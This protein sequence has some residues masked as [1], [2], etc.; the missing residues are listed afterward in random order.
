MKKMYIFC[1]KCIVHIVDNN[2]GRT[3]ILLGVQ[4]HTDLQISAIWIH[5]VAILI[6]CIVGIPTVSFQ[7]KFKR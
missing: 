2:N 6:I 7:K 3:Y 1:S 5:T 4:L